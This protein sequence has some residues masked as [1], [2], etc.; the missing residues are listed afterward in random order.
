MIMHFSHLNAGTLR[1][2]FPLLLLALH[3]RWVRIH[4]A[5]MRRL[6][7]HFARRLRQHTVSI[8]SLHRRAAV[9]SLDPR[10]SAAR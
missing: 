4:N 3:S 7:R 5:L 6:N 8:R 1:T 2:G 10:Q 9:A